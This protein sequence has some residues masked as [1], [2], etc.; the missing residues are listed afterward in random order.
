MPE[1]LREQRYQHSCGYRK[2]H[3]P[4]LVQRSVTT[5]TSA[6]R[7]QEAQG[8]L[9][10]ERMC[11]A[12]DARSVRRW[13]YYEKHTAHRSALTQSPKVPSWPREAP[14]LLSNAGSSPQAP[15]LNLTLCHTHPKSRS[16]HTHAVQT[17]YNRSQ[18][19]GRTSKQH[20]TTKPPAS[21]PS[22]VHA[23][24]VWN[25][26]HLLWCLATARARQGMPSLDS[27]LQQMQALKPRRYTQKGGKQLKCAY[28][29][30][31]SDQ[32]CRSQAVPDVCEKKQYTI[33]AA[34]VR[35]FQPTC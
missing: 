19:G 8:A 29:M 30:C 5:P 16:L 4:R 17:Q 1:H 28:N 34:P 2:K 10:T 9:Q 27:S 35:C 3:A 23:A 32:A 31:R 22:H 12:R 25:T 14:T 20:T 6:P 33:Q 18:T 26:V 24:A 11:T 21:P 15:L 7:G 13:P